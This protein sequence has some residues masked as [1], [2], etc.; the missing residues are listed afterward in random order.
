[1]DGRGIIWANAW[2]LHIVVY[3][4]LYSRAMFLLLTDDF[5]G[6]GRLR[7][8]QTWQSTGILIE[9]SS[10]EL[11]LGCLS[12]GTFDKNYCCYLL[13][14]EYLK[15]LICEPNWCLLNDLTISY[16]IDMDLLRPTQPCLT[17]VGD[18]LLL[19]LDTKNDY[20]ALLV[21]M[22]RLL[23]ECWWQKKCKWRT[24]Y[25]RQHAYNFNSVF[26][27]FLLQTLKDFWQLGMKFEDISTH[28]SKET[29]KAFVSDVWNFGSW[30]GLSL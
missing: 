25:S 23:P 26:W 12:I 8:N 6:S 22:F 24:L 1:M 14:K 4:R 13:E 27:T 3:H 11:W 7:I 28:L 30:H 19:M 29:S 5:R 2:G 10:T 16:W 15:L 20:L 9:Y 17:V 18:V 21:T